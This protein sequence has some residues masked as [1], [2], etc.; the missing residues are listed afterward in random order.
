MKDIQR[1]DIHIISRHSNLTE[2]GIDSVLKEKVYNDKEAWQKFLRLFFITL[3]VGFTVSG[4]VFFFAYN[5][6][7]LHKF[8]KIG[9]TEGLIIAITSLA[10][11][12]K[13][14]AN[15]RN[16][17]LTGAAV[18]VGVLFAV[19][20]QI[21]QTGANAYDFFLAWTVFVTLWVLVANFAPLWLLYLILINATF[22]LYAQ[23]V[24]KDWSEVLVFS[25]L[26]I[27]NTAVLVSAILLS[28]YK[29]IVDVPNWFLNIVA[30]GCTTYATIGI[31][32]GIFDKYQIAF[33][34]LILIAS[35]VYALGIW[36]GLK[37]KS[38]FYLSVVPFS[39]IVIVSALLIKISEGEMMFLLVSLFIVASITLVIKNLIDIQ[40]KWANEA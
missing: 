2:Q 15:I 18:L 8:A 28:K 27:I 32:I 34:I 25:L 19:F 21:Y 40:K 35:I 1:E 39:L 36:H 22:I 7:D 31:V 37:A 23:Q 11:L 30:L 10:L 12:P 9:I 16:I 3:G 5:W 17:I 14:N 6:E 29:K 38:G 20:G 4:I 33:L 13:I 26:F 24:A